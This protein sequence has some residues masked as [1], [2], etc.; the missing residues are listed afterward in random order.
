MPPARDDTQRWNHR[1]SPLKLRLMNDKI[2]VCVELR[3][4]LCRVYNC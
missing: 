4:I 2:V 1:E 3:M